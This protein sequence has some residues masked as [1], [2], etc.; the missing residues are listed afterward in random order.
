MRESTLA[1]FGEEAISPVGAN[2]EERRE[3]FAVVEEMAFGGGGELR[4]C[5][6]G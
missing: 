1:D 2:R 3:F 6:S 5:E 4:W